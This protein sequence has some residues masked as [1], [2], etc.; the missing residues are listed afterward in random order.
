VFLQGCECGL[1]QRE[2]EDRGYMLLRDAL[3][4]IKPRRASLYDDL[5]D[6]PPFTEQQVAEF[7]AVME[8]VSDSVGTDGEGQ[9]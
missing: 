2:W 7:A 6:L 4:Q 1:P 8:Q 5:P 3:A 9:P